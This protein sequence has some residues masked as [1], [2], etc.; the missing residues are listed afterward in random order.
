VGGPSPTL[1]KVR[2]S[3]LCLKTASTK[4]ERRMTVIGNSLLTGTEGS[5]CWPDPTCREVCCL[6]GTQVRDISR[7]LSSLIH[8]CDYYPLL[9]SGDSDEVAERSLRTIKRDFK[10]TGAVS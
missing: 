2:Q 8:P 3:T 9:I 1:F 6:P 7:K 4:E 5:I 10:G